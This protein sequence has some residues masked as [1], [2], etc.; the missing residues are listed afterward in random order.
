M[1]WVC[2]IFL[3]FCR[4][5]LRGQIRSCA[6]ASHTVSKDCSSPS[7]LLFALDGQL[8]YNSLFYKWCDSPVPQGVCWQVPARALLSISPW[9]LPSKQASGPA[10]W[11]K[12]GLL[13]HL[14]KLGFSVTI[15]NFGHLKNFNEGIRLRVCLVVQHSATYASKML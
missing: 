5:M 8:L 10:A 9:G 13:E 14:L 6:N 7:V 1:T 15:V 4:D 12:T 2:I 11:A 3:Y